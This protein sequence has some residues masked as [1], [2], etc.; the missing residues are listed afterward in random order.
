MRCTHGLCGRVFDWHTKS[1]IYEKSRQAD[2]REV[3]CWHCGRLGAKRAFTSA[4]ADLTVKGTW[5]KTAA[6]EL[7]GKSF[8]TKQERD[9]QLAVSGTSVI[10]G[11][12][13]RGVLDKKRRG[14][15]PEKRTAVRNAVTALLSENGE[16]RLKDII[17][18]TG[19]SSS[20]INDVL[21]K[22]PGRIQ[23]VGW[24]LYNLTGGDDQT[25]GVAS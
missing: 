16:M 19:F 23:K 2:F 10:D 14:P 1:A 9:R 5:G 17:S 15:S 8:Y 20:A 3:R 11:G 6:P 21:Y 4:P 12:E 7:K 24:G 13:S 18:K 22:D 25:A